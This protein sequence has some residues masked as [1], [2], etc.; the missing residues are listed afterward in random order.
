M[1]SISFL[2]VLIFRIHLSKDKFI[3]N[4][5]EYHPKLTKYHFFEN[6]RKNR[7]IA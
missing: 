6:L 4:T 5:S 7:V 1:T 3:V 2:M